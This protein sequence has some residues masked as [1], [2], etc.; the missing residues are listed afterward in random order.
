[1]EQFNGYITQFMSFMMEMLEILKRIV[2]V[3]FSM[4]IYLV[5]FFFIFGIAILY[6]AR[7]R[8]KY[9]K[10]LEDTKIEILKENIEFGQIKE[11]L[12]KQNYFLKKRVRK[13]NHRIA[14]VEHYALSK[15]MK[16]PTN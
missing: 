6:R 5:L 16:T 8:R 11:T 9:I 10:Y 1:M 15:L 12:E 3:E 4:N 2:E 13:Q 14:K 7:K